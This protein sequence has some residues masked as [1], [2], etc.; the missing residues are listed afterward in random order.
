[1]T[2]SQTKI[3]TKI[4]K[5]IIIDSNIIKEHI[6]T[7]VKLRNDTRSFMFRENA[8]LIVRRHQEF[9]GVIPKVPK[10]IYFM[11]IMHVDEK[12]I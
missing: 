12:S 4:N 3:E 6:K 8:Q 5:L 11:V 7:I 10:K 1:M 9:L 2:T